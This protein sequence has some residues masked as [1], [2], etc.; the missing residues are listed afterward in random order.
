M[1]KCSSIFGNVDAV[2]PIYGYGRRVAFEA[3][4]QQ[5]SARKRAEIMDGDLCG[6]AGFNP[7]SLILQDELHLIEGPLGSMVGAYEMAIDVL[8]GCE[9]KPKYIASSATIKEAESQVGTIFRRA[10]ET[11]PPSGI[12]SSDSYF[13]H[14]VED[15]PCAREQ[16]GRLYIGIAT[17]KSTV[18][19]PIK[20]QSIAM[21]EIHKIRSR[22][23][24]Y[25]LTPEERKDINGAT[26]P[27]WTFVSYFTDLLLMSKFTSYYSEN[28]IENVSKR[29][30]ERTHNS[31]SQTS[32]SRIG[33]G[34]CLLPI[35]AEHDMEVSSVSVYCAK[36][37][38]RIRLGV[39]GDGCPVGKLAHE[40]EHQTC[41]TGE[42][43]FT[44]PG[45][46]LA[47]N[48]GERIWIAV[49]ND[50]GKAEFR[51]VNSKEAAWERRREVGA[52]DY[53]DA[54][55]GL[56]PLVGDVPMISL[57][58]RPRHL[59]SEDNITLSS[60]TSSEDL[61]RSLERLQETSEI[62]SLQTSPV[63]G[64]GIDVDRLG[65]MGVMNQP[66]TSSGY[67]QSTGR[68]GRTA[69]GLVIT[70]LRA[71][72][73]RDLNHYENFVGYHRAMHRFVEPVTPRRPS[74]TRR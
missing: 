67:I 58:A 36:G 56:V 68:V 23:D 64:T 61:A 66:K 71:G 21:S 24:G 50:G 16:A 29:S 3:P 62:D 8:S 34:L 17:T 9:P 63:F 73:V 26:D 44:V 42:N 33:T 65:I 20:A 32:N 46:P 1:P 52:P 51:M 38:G 47:V 13:S 5:R 28:V 41:I 60:E 57:N 14:T 69:P 10:I 59:D 49:I 6:V 30:A 2:H 43:V 54:C 7:P 53:P 4:L 35:R 39:Y 55:D 48:C 40:F 15:I 37:D 12:D 45:Q 11:F 31:E 72:R 18:T 25:D 70:W 27:Y 19:L 74:R 22:P